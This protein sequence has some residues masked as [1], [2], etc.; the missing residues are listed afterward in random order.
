LGNGSAGVLHATV[1]RR[2]FGK[3]ADR[4]L[5]IVD[6]SAY[7]SWFLAAWRP[8]IGKRAFLAR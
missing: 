1:R 2:F 8:R 4:C 6:S 5:G 7:Y 3:I